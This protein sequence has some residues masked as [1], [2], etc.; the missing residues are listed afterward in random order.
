[1]DSPR[2]GA[3]SMSASETGGSANGARLDS[4]KE[5]AAYLRRDVATVRRWEKREGLP[6]RRHQHDKLGSVYAIAAEIDEWTRSRSQSQ[7][8]QPVATVDRR[9]TLGPAAWMWMTMSA[10]L[11]AVAAGAFMAGARW[12][13]PGEAPESRFLL[14]TPE[15]LVVNSLAISPDGSQIALAGAAAGKR[16][17][18][19]LREI[20]ATMP[21]Q[22]L[23]TEGGSLPF[24][25]PDGRHIGFFAGG[26]LKRIDLSDGTV[27]TICSAGNG[28]GGTWSKDDVIVFASRADEP[29]MRVSA[30]GGAA[31]PLTSLTDPASAGH[32]WPEFL[33]DGRRVLYYAESSNSELEGVYVVGLDS[34]PPERLLA[35][36]SNAIPTSTGQ[37]LFVRDHRLMAQSLDVDTL[38]LKGEA[39]AVAEPVLQ[40]HAFRGKGDF[41]VSAAGVLAFRLGSTALSP[42]VW[43]D[44]HGTQL[45]TVGEPAFYGAPILSPDGKRTAVVVWNL[46][47]HTLAMA[48]WLIDVAT[49]MATR[50]TVDPR[51]NFMP[52]WSPAGDRVAF[53]SRHGDVNN[54]VQ[55]AV[56]G[57]ASEHLVFEPQ[58]QVLPEAWSSDG[59]LIFYSV[60]AKD[61]GYDTWALPLFGDRKPFPVLRSEHS[62]A[63][64]QLSP[65]GRLLSYTSD[66]TGQ[67]QV[68]VT[69]F[70]S[71]KGTRQISVGGGGDARWRRD[72]RELFYIASDGRL[73]AVAIDPEPN[74][75]HGA[76]QPL[77]QTRIRLLWEDMRNHYDVTADGQRFLF[78]VPVDDARTT[79]FTVVT[80]WRP[81]LR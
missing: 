2:T 11:I 61:T 32:G 3:K 37:L 34:G 6:V 80:P 79:P 60:Y 13:R 16:D 57:I 54:L 59:R 12:T 70:P 4:W 68:Y 33:P 36:A 21:R 50:L 81:A 76:P 77:F 39:V 65:D 14:A 35:V 55:K 26:K 43:I 62:E 49:G 18:L 63:Q 25:A 41:S 64:A 29:L 44:R 5:I 53:A 56:N 8:R 67:L 78:T 48:T 46:E 17:S 31:R 72:G 71:R 40:Q 27:E 75:T 23:K 28:R 74:F 52:L 38:E 22:L 47:S 10:L 15:G 19:W 66:E 30:R 69:S 42:L 51:P 9:G 58:T 20:N 1:M 24:W 7:A 73:M 45:G